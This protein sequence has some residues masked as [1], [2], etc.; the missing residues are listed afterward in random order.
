M[1]ANKQLSEQVDEALFIYAS[2]GRYVF[3]GK[4]HHLQCDQIGQFIAL[5]ATFQNLWQK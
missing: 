1:F 3:L 2:L 5:W 4:R